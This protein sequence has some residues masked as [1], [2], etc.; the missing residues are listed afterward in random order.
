MTPGEEG[1][2]AAIVKRIVLAHGGRVWAEGQVDRGATFYFTL[3]EA[4]STPARSL[5]PGS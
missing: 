3:G 5:P 4:G 1:L 2:R